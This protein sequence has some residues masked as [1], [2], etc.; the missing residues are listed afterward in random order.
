MATIRFANWK[1]GLILRDGAACIFFRHSDTS[2]WTQV[3]DK[4][5]CN[6]KI[7]DVHPGTF[8]DSE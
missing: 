7:L 3:I 6:I 1:A 2:R 8:A 4:L 5:C